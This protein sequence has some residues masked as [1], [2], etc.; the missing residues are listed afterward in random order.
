M[1]NKYNE[2]LNHFFSDLQWAQATLPISKNSL[3]I[4]RITDVR[5]LAFLSSTSGVYE[6]ITKS[7]LQLFTFAPINLFQYC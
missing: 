4:L 5:L 6:L 2:C 1:Q 3:G 7:G